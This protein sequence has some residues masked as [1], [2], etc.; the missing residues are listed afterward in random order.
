MIDR[1]KANLAI[2]HKMASV[3]VM[4]AASFAAAIWLGLDPA[5]QAAVLQALPIP[6]WL[7]P[8]GVGA[9]GAVARVWPQKSITPAEAVN[10]S[11]Q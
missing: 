10:K 3:W 5:Q 1:L 7:V 6:P 9:V 8:V 4:T 2:A 11:A